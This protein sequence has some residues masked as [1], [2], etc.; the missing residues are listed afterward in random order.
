MCVYDSMPMLAKLSSKAS[1]DL[2]FYA[3]ESSILLQTTST[4]DFSK[5]TYEETVSSSLERGFSSETFV[6]SRDALYACKSV[7]CLLHI[8][9]SQV[10]T[11]DLTVIIT[12]LLTFWCP[13]GLQQLPY[14]FLRN[15]YSLHTFCGMHLPIPS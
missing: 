6:I 2:L 12:K 11:A 8:G 4:M 9:C 10:T 3:K 1:Y 5:S 15:I 14:I 13:R 7:C